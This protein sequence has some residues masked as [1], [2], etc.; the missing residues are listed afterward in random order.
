MHDKKSYIIKLSHCRV[1][2]PSVNTPVTQLTLQKVPTNMSRG[3]CAVNASHHTVFI[4]S[5]CLYR[6]LNPQQCPQKFRQYRFSGIAFVICVISSPQS[7]TMLTLH[8]LCYIVSSITSN[9]NK[10]S[11]VKDFQRSKISSGLF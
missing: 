9:V 7:P 2:T 5:L 11:E 6:L 4:V 3:N 8:H 10:N 1:I